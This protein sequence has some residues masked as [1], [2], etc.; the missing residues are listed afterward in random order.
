MIASIIQENTPRLVLCG[1][2]SIGA[3]VAGVVSAR[4]NLPL[5]SYC[6]E[7]QSGEE[8]L[9]F[10]SQICGGKL[11]VE[12]AVPVPTA[13]VTM[14]PGVFKSEQGRDSRSKEVVS[15]PPPDL[16]GLQVALIGYIEPA[17]GDVDISKETILVSIGRGIQNQDNIILAEELADAL[18]GT[19]CASRPVVD[20]GWL[21]TTRLVGKSGKQVKPK[22]YLALG[23][24]GAPEHVEAIAN[25]EMVIA[26]NT[27]PSAP[28]FNNARYGIVMDMFELAPVLAEKARLAKTIHAG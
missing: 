1:E 12:G 3:E 4:L 27:D 15:I 22:L 6:R 13:F 21:P 26:I 24:S 5:I 14:I 25:C 8:G 2:T 28:I 9:R 23:I 16:S 17:A 18:G 19:V 7:V 11:M 10:I 20:Q